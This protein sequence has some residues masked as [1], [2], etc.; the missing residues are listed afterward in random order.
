MDIC[1]TQS[2]EM[3][4][5]GFTLLSNVSCG[6]CMCDETEQQAGMDVGRCVCVGVE[7]GVCTC[8]KQDQDYTSQNEPVTVHVGLLSV[9]KAPQAK[10][11]FDRCVWCGVWHE[12][13][14]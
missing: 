8:A 5:V 3:A 1:I 12:H 13:V 11:D 2:T 10:M 4:F 6:V 9:E 14:C 7:C